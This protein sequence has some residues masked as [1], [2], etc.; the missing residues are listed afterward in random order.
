MPPRVEET[1]F[2]YADSESNWSGKD[3][4]TYLNCLSRP[5]LMDFP[6]AVAAGYSQR[7]SFSPALSGDGLNQ[8]P[9]PWQTLRFSPPVHHWLSGVRDPSVGFDPNGN[10]QP[11]PN[12]AVNA[13][14]VA[15]ANPQPVAQPNPQPVAQPHPQPVAQPN[16]QPVAPAN[17]PQ[18]AAAPANQPAIPG[19][20]I[21][22][23]MHANQGVWL[24]A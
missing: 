24:A 16:P 3:D 11:A 10:V 19:L 17:P 20:R 6:D 23:P 18:L 2:D 22:A 15:Q 9:Y 12:G 5:I 21:S 7:G 1:D 4:G 13:Q 14:A 8:E